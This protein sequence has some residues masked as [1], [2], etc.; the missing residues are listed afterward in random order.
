MHKI[1]NRK[2][3][4]NYMSHITVNIWTYNQLSQLVLKVIR[5][6][7]MYMLS[8]YVDGQVQLKEFFQ[9]R[10]CLARIREPPQGETKEVSIALHLELVQAG[11]LP[12]IGSPEGLKHYFEISYGLFNGTNNH[13]SYDSRVLKVWNTSLKKW[14]S[15]E[16]SKPKS[17]KNGG[18]L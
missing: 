12:M 7:A 18:W 8:A 9:A 5:S 1:N 15:P 4:S 6:K 17:F 3:I 2:V 14:M 10:W 16:G 11:W 13:T